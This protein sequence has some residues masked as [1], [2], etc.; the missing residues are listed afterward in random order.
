MISADNYYF[1]RDI[2]IAVVSVISILAAT[3]LGIIMSESKPNLRVFI[4][5]LG[6]MWSFGVMMAATALSLYHALKP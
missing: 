4:I 1:V 3:T 2:V 5:M 6:V